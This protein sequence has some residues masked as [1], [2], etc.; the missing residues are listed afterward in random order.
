[1]FD[2]APLSDIAEERAGSLE[3][4]PRAPELALKTATRLEFSQHRIH[5]AQMC[6]SLLEAHSELSGL[7][8]A[9][10]L[11]KPLRELGE[12]TSKIEFNI[13]SD[14][15]ARINT[16]VFYDFQQVCEGLQRLPLK[17]I[18]TTSTAQE[19]FQWFVSNPPELAQHRGKY[20]AVLD[21]QFVADGATMREVLD[22]VSKQ[23]FRRRPVLAFVPDEGAKIFAH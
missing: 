17:P 9:T 21:K 11:L 12:I 1:M 18:L 7:L 20:V 4:E 23:K 10:I 3:R 2:T 5:I 6:S 14:I 16:F 15:G 22:N 8:D 19:D 13:A